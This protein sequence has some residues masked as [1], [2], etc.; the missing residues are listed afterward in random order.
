MAIHKPHPRLDEVFP[1]VDKRVVVCSIAPCAYLQGEAIGSAKPIPGVEVPQGEAAR[2]MAQVY[3]NGERVQRSARSH[4]RDPA[5]TE[6]CHQGDTTKGC[7]S[8]N[9]GVECVCNSVN[10]RWETDKSKVEVTV[11]FCRIHSPECLLDF[12]ISTQVIQTR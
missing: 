4:S 12:L 3:L 8:R 9:G 1:G 10:V 11:R 7:R 5:R 2:C 6:G